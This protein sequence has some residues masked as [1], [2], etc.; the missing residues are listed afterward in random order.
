MAAQPVTTK[1]LTGPALEEAI[2]GLARLRVTVF[3]EFPYLYD[4]DDGYETRYLE[5]YRKSEGAIVVGA[6]D[7][8]RLV[9]AATG[10]PMLQHEA[11]FAAAFDGLG[12]DLA[13]LFYC[14]ESVLL[15]L[16]R[17]RGIGH[18]F[19]DAREA[20]ARGL[21][22]THCC[23]CAVVRP[24]DHPARPAGYR[25]LDAFWEKRGYRKL[26]GV[27]ATYRWKDIGEAQES[28]KAMQFWLRQL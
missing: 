7:G 20:H 16:Y 2:P 19:F 6:Y 28:G 25:P 10:T 4:G 22:A 21:G 23:F 17:G 18:A 13:K 27:T 12:Y 14:G 5:T 26:D 24:A 15:P 1:T 3:A 8:E 9:G 11:E